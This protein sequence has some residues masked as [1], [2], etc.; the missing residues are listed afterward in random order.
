MYST[1]PNISNY[2]YCSFGKTGPTGPAGASGPT[3]ASGAPGPTGA[4]GPTGPAG[5]LGPTGASGPAGPGVTG[6]NNLGL[7]GARVLSNITAGIINARSLRTTG[8]GLTISESLN[9]IDFTVPAY[10]IASAPGGSSLVAS[11]FTNAVIR[12]VIGGTTMSL[13]ST[14]NSITFNS[15]AAN[16][17]TNLG[18]LPGSEGVLVNVAA[19]SVRAKSLLANGNIQVSS[20]ANHIYFRPLINVTIPYS[21]RTI[22]NTYVSGN[23]ELADFI[24][25]GNSVAITSLDQTPATYTSLPNAF[26]GWQSPYSAAIRNV[27]IFGRFSI[28]TTIT[29]PLDIYSII[30]RAIEG[31]S[32][33]QVVHFEK[34]FNAT[35]NIA[36]GD[37]IQAT[38]DPTADIDVGWHLY[39]SFYAVRPDALGNQNPVEFYTSASMTLISSDA[40]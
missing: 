12:S 11:G 4:S 5:A 25:F 40:L 18:T 17:V 6:V 1:S 16:T 3:G 26:I 28:P 7:P 24:G 13:N 38:Y 36:V 21:G 8:A 23:P 2:T 19:N 27:K 15:S 35:S 14:A 10:S 30:H 9:N 22:L 31:D 39:F 20:D 34:I 32:A 29:E 37:I 33:L